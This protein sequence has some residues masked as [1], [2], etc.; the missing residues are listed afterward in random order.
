MTASRETL[1]AFFAAENRRDWERYA[2]FLHPE[3]E[4]LIDGRA[5]QGRAAY[6]DAIVAAY[7]GSDAQ[8]RVHQVIRSSD[9]ERIAALLV[10][11]EGNRSLDVFE[12]EDGL[13]LAR[14]GRGLE[15]RGGRV[16]VRPPAPRDVGVTAGCP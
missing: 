14:P 4:W 1:A 11:S 13:I 3:V 10:D 15:R 16:P 7:A 6:L 2:E 8:F 9:R 12:F 5:V